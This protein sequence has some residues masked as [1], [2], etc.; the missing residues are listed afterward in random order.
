MFDVLCTCFNLTPRNIHASQARSAALLQSCLSATPGEDSFSLLLTPGAL[1]VA[2]Q[3]I[4][5]LLSFSEA[6]DV[7][8]LPELLESLLLGSLQ[9]ISRHSD[10]Q[11]D[12]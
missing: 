1:R 7:G 6:G 2:H 3:S 11:A 10:L 5:H 8:F 4:A 12:V 9:E